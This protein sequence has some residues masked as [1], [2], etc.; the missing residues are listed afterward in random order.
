MR[1]IV[2]APGVTE[3]RP[4][5]RLVDP[6]SDPTP[7]QANVKDFDDRVRDV[8]R[9]ILA[10]ARISQATLAAA[11]EVSQSS[12]SHMLTDRSYG[13]TTGE[14][15]MIEILAKVPAGTIYRQLGFLDEPTL[16]QRV[17]DIP[18][19]DEQ[20]AEV[21]VAAIQ[22]IKANVMRRTARS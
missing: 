5:P 14:I 13:L 3:K 12:V 9:G 21:V 19:I 17:Y 22:A 10:S 20:A 8:A 6:P 4:R 16:E 2:Y 11:L 18:G 15:G 7:F 1:E